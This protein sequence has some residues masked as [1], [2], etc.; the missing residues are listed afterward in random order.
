MNDGIDMR[1]T[2]ISPFVPVAAIAFAVIG[3]AG[4]GDDGD[5]AS[6]GAGGESSVVEIAAV[7]YEFLASESIT[8]APGDTVIF[9]VTNEGEL[10][11]E[12]QVLTDENRRLGQT[13]RISPGD[14]D[15]VTVTF[16]D[17]GVYQVICDI[18]DHFSRGQRAQ[19]TVE[20]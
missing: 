3:L 15:E 4:C 20:A 14:T 7:E 5:S 16:T 9:R 10:D 8:I 17:V 11:H 19:F 18:D 13:D 6:D 1:R 2:R 12:L